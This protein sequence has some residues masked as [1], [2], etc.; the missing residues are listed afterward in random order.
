[1]RLPVVHHPDYQAPLHDGHLFPMSK[2]GYLREELMARGLT[3]PDEWLT[4]APATEA[5]VARAHAPDY[6][7]RVFAGTLT[8]EEV[9]RIGYPHSERVTRRSR[10]ASAGTLIAARFALEA[11][12]ACNTAG[13]SHH[14]RHEHGA[15]FCVFN[16]VAI[17]VRSLQRDGGLGPVLVLDCD[18]HQGDGTAV[19]FRDDPGVFTVSLH[20]RGNYPFEKEQ[21]DLDVALPDGSGDTV[22]LDALRET[23]ARVAGEG[24]FSI[25]FYNAGVDVHAD[26]RL[27]RLTLSDEGIRARDRMVMDWAMSEGVP[28]TCVLGGGY[29]SDRRRLAG[30]HAI[31][32]EE[33]QASLTAR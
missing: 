5:M 2:Y 1:V 10:L 26:D 32:F 16:D 30:R 27:G 24:P 23:L 29:D 6:V 22:Y 18:V 21:S 28:L 33:A 15:G 11:G 12:I 17:A 9:K 14:A 4:P 31:L 13:G 8:R 20:A 25:A 7:G 19:I 3:G